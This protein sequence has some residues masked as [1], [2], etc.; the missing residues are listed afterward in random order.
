MPP[1]PKNTLDELAFLTHTAGGQ[2]A[3]QTLCPKNANPQPKDFYWFGK[4]G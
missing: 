2:V 4:N 3:T 1:N